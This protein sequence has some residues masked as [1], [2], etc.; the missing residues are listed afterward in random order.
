MNFL[1]DLKLLK[2]FVAVVH[3]QGFANAQQELNLSTSAI[4]TYMSNLEQKVGVTLCYRGRSGFTLT[5]KGH[6]F[7]QHAVNLLEHLQQFEQ[8][9][10]NLSDEQRG[11]FNLGLLDAMQG[12][13]SL[14]ISTIIGQYSA[15][16]PSIH[17]HLTILSPYE[18]QLAVLDNRLDLAI[19]AFTTKMNGLLY[20]P[21]YSEQQWLY[22]GKRHF[23]F[24]DLNPTI[25]Q[26]N[27]CRMV[28]RSYLSSALSAKY[29]IKDAAATVESME[30]QLIL[31]LSGAYIGYL[32]AHYA[33]SFV[34][35]KQL[36]CLNPQDF[37]Y[38]AEFQLIAH[39]A[40]LKEPLIAQFRQLVTRYLK[41]PI[42]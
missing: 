38:V 35:Q 1:T 30:A 11:R 41:D 6:V 37:G 31:I 9:T 17:L 34:A 28:G 42:L 21:L 39:K 3:Q 5:D 33:A 13:D 26:I 32:P 18:L 27:A 14:P 19:G 4:S 8:Q 23:L 20:Q 15:R 40:R 24:D 25:D 10:L 16:Y 2:I 36:K 29:G 7:Y 22:C 12:D